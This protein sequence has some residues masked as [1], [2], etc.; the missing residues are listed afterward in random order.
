M[1]TPNPALV[2]AAPTLVQAIGLLQ[3][4]CNTVLVGDPLQA[5]LRVAPALQVLLG[6]LTLL[7]P[8]VLAA[9]VGVV[10]TEVQAKLSALATQLQALL[11]KP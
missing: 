2:A 7:E 8:G 9:E 4:F 6:Q 3:T 10:N 11:P 1:T 5:G